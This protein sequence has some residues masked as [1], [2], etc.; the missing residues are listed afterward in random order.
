MKK[1][2]KYIDHTL[3]KPEAT[4]KQIEEL[5]HQA[6]KYDFASVCVNS[7]YASYCYQL[8]KDSDVKVCCVV[9]FP[10]GACDSKTKAFETKQAIAAGAQEIDMVINIGLAK[11][12]N[13]QAVK[14]DIAEVVNA[15]EGKTVKVIIETC[16][17]TDDEKAEACICAMMADATFV[18]TSTGFSKSGATVEDVF[19]MKSVVGKKCQVK[20]AGGIRTYDDALKMIEAGADRLGCSSSVAIMQQYLEKH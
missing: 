16:L 17:L 4:H 14:D 11:E 7:C 20:A 19:L 9:G 8:L 18:K 13:W 1:L 3:L 2:N 12:H 15:A 10:L 6:L 5:C